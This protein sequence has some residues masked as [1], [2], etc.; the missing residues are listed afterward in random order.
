MSAT[1]LSRSAPTVSPLRR[2]AADMK[3]ENGGSIGLPMDDDE[4][5]SVGVRALMTATNMLHGSF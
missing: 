2:S 3:R 1:L 4:H 5:I